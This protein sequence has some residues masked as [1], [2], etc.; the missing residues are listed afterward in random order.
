VS[1]EGSISYT[2]YADIYPR[3]GGGGDVNPECHVLAEE[4]STS[5]KKSRLLFKIELKTEVLK[6]ERKIMVMS[7]H[8]PSAVS[9]CQK[10]VMARGPYLV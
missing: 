3:I 2:T 8:G 1:T 7:K 5:F 4:D 10:N 6:T 9:D